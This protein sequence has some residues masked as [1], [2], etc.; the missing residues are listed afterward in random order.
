[1]SPHNVV[2]TV[3]VNGLVELFL[4]SRKGRNSEYCGTFRPEII[5][6]DLCAVP[7]VAPGLKD[8]SAVANVL[9][10]HRCYKLTTWCDS[11]TPWMKAR[12]AQSRQ[13]V[14]LP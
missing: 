5:K 13:K 9:E 1:M 6:H 11:W 3:V 8:A 12:L 10:K 4:A 2:P 7:E 14:L